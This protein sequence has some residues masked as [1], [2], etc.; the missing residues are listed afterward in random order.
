MSKYALGFRQ[1]LKAPTA[2]ASRRL[3][4]AQATAVLIAIGRCE[5]G[6]EDPPHAG[7]GGAWLYCTILHR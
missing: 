7:G 3:M 1:R 4:A 5:H 6:E 2:G